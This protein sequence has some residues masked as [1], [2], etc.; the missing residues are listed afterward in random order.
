MHVQHIS[1]LFVVS[2]MYLLTEWEGWTGKYLAQGP[3]VLT[4]SQ[5]FSSPARPYSV[6]KHFIIW[7]LTVLFEPK[8][9]RDYIRSDGWARGTITP[10]STTKNCHLFLLFFLLFISTRRTRNSQFR[11]KHNSCFQKANR[12]L[13][14]SCQKYVK[15]INNLA[16]DKKSLHAS[17]KLLWRLTKMS[18]SFQAICRPICGPLGFS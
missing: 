13:T 12:K 2:T 11:E 9:G 4:E 16:S 8:I 1:I 18:A 17:L 3:Y 14:W 6:N 5:I 10:V 7:P 15:A